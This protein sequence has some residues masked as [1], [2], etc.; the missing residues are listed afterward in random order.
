MLVMVEYK[1]FAKSEIEE[2]G[3]TNCLEESYK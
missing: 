3:N 1:M 2:V